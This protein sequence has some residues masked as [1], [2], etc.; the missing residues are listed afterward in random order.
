MIELNENQK[1]EE[2][3]DRIRRFQADLKGLLDNYKVELVPIIK[4][5]PYGMIPQLTINDKKYEK[6][7]SASPSGIILPEQ[8]AKD[9]Q[10]L[11]DSKEVVE[12][13]TKAKKK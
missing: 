6:L 12:R 4:Y 1:K 7:S 2:F 8:V 3:N 9:E 13:A 10:S 5:A 11:A